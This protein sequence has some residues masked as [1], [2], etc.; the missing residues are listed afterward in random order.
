MVLDMVE[1]E[2]FQTIIDGLISEANSAVS[3]RTVSSS[4]S[5]ITGD[6]SF[7]SGAAATHSVI[8]A[9]RLY[10]KIL[11]REGLFH[12]CDAFIISN[13]SVTFKRGDLISHAGSVYEVRVSE[14][15]RWTG[16]AIFNYSSLYAKS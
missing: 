4:I 3:V 15:R 7:T 10:S 13:G 14:A 8:W 5:N 6:K 16:S 1:A 11:D 2:E 12:D 9:N